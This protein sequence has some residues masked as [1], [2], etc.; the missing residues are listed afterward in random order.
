MEAAKEQ[1]GRH[2]LNIAVNSLASLKRAIATP[3]VVIRVKEHW[4]EQLRG[5]TR[6]PEK[7][8]GKGY[9]FR[10]PDWKGEIKRMWA[11]TPK[12]SELRFNEDGS[13]TFYPGADKS[14]T[15]VFEVAQ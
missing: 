2:T 13:V 9:F 3:N 5:T 14:W 11:P 10:G 8:Q 4:Q 1:A 15:L 6:T 12:A 7:I